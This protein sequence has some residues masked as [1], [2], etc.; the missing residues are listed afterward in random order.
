[1]V[2][3]IVT[4]AAGNPFFTEELLAAG[5]DADGVPATVEDVLLTRTARL[6]ASARRVLQAAAVLGRSVPHE[7]LAAVADPA[8]L[9]AGLAAAVTHRLLEPRGDGDL[10][11]HPPIP[12]TGAG[13]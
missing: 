5:I 9:D 13:G 2:D 11:R 6:P 8:D 7:L 12:E 3:R 10:F 1:M 4:R